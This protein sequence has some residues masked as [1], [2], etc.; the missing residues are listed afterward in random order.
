MYRNNKGVHHLQNKAVDKAEESF[1]NSMVD[2][3][4]NPI[5]HLNLG[6]TF[7]FDGQQDKKQNEES[8][9]PNP[10]FEK[11]LKEYESVL[12]LPALPKELQFAAQFNAGNAAAQNYN[13]DLALKHYQAALDINP[14]SQEVRTNI[15]LLLKGDAGKGKGKGGKGEGKKNDENDQEG[16]GQN[17]RDNPNQDPSEQKQQ[18]KP[19]FKGENL[20]KEDVRKILEELKS[21]EAK[22]RALEYGSKGKESTPD[23]DW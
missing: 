1:L 22:I 16:Q 13:I 21:Q 10:K 3:P 18:E 8:E 2:D 15:E 11:A 14:D 7:E 12:R 23:K 20:T 5:L 9:E 17:P 4:F 19:K 6:R